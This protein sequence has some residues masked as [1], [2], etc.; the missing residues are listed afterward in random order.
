ML[1]AI[2]IDGNKGIVSIAYAIV[3]GENKESWCKFLELLKRN[4]EID[5]VSQ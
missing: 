1:T 4:L 3:E 5:Y 2:G